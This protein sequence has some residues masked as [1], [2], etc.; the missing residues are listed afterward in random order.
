LEEDL[1]MFTRQSKDLSC[2]NFSPGCRTIKSL[3]SQK[4]ISRHS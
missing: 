4:L 1:F 2:Q 3:R